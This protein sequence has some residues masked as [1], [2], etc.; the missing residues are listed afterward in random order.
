MSTA[1]LKIDLIGKIMNLREVRIME[2][3]K[4]I[5]DFET[6]EGEYSLSNAQRD[7]I[8]EAQND[9][10]L[11]EEEANNDIEKWLNEQ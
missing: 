4:K 5:I 11:T 9:K 10:I 1:E 3:I 7:R 8:F 2:E 6:E